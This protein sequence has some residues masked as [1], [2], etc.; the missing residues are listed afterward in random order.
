VPL[1]R[2]RSRVCS[3]RITAASVAAEGGFVG[4]GVTAAPGYEEDSPIF[5]GEGDKNQIK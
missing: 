2:W 4:L 5:D 1:S 3:K